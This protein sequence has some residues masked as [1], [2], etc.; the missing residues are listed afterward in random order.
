MNNRSRSFTLSGNSNT[1][2]LT[3]VGSGGPTGGNPNSCSNDWLLVGC[4]RISDQQP[5]S[6]TCEDRICGGVF[7]A[8]VG[9]VPRTVTSSIRP[10][11]L[12][13]HTNSVEAPTDID[14]IGFC[15]DYVQQ[16]CTNS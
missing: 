11:R 6:P 10:F 13:F 14:N 1:E 4:A 16:P 2:V 3:M 8:T 15:L 9:N 12:F 7:S 5:I